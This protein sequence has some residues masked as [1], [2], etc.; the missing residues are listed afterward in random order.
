MDNDRILRCDWDENGGFLEYG[1]SY[2]HPDLGILSQEYRISTLTYEGQRVYQSSFSLFG[3]AADVPGDFAYLPKPVKAQLWGVIFAVKHKFFAECRPD[4]VEHFI[5]G[6]YSFELREARYRAHLQPPGYARL[7]QKIRRTITYQKEQ[8]PT[9]P[10]RGLFL[11]A[12]PTPPGPA[13]L[14]A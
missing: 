8:T 5:D 4:I 3:D 13:A 1:L 9:S 2:L 11:L 12:P 10:G 7:A 6:A 14:P